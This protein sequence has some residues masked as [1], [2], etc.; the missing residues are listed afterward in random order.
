MVHAS[1]M[2]PRVL[3]MDPEEK[4]LLDMKSSWDGMDLL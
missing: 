3:V 2:V 4:I 1:I